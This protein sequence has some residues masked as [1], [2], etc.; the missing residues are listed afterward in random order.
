MAPGQP[1]VPAGSAQALPLWRAVE[2]QHQVST[3]VLV[4]TLAEQAELERLL[5]ESKPAP[6]AGR[7]LHW[8]LSTPFRYPPL[9]GGSRFRGPADPGAWYGADTVRTA[10]AE[11]GYW[12]WR[13]LRASPQ[14][15]ALPARAQTVFRV[16]AA[17]RTVDLRLPPLDALRGRF[18]AP[19]DYTATQSFARRARQAGVEILRYESV[20]DPEHG[21]AAVLFTPAAFS[22]VAPLE[23]QT[24]L[25]DVQAAR[26]TWVYASALVP[27][28]FEFAW[29][30]GSDEAV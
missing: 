1:M 10:C 21:G 2:A 15:S 23:L 14:L 6:P 16:A 13:F 7:E 27:A 3:N 28:A 26:V 25:L 8:L 18:T 17:G 5:E 19:A 24:W 4:D 29:G 11:V 12:R 30:D 22:A 9:A 20:R